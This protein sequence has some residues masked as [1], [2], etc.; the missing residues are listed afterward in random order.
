MKKEKKT[1]EQHEM[2]RIFP[3]STIL[4]TGKEVGLSKLFKNKKFTLLYKGTRDGFG[5]ADFYRLVSK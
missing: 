1:R 3:Y 5:S 2:S 4:E